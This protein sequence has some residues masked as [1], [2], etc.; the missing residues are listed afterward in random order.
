MVIC[1]PALVRGP[2]RESRWCHR[3]T[4]MSMLLLGG[5]LLRLGTGLSECLCYYGH[6]CGNLRGGTRGSMVLQLSD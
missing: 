3:G 5:P 6:P 2:C 1:R 4:Y